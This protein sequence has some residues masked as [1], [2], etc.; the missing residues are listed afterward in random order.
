[1]PSDSWE[2]QA[3]NWLGWARTPCHDA[4]WDY[5]SG[6]FDHIVPA[7]GRATLDLGCGEGRVARD[8]S[9]R[10]HRVI[11]LD[12]S[13]T[14]LAAAKAADPGGAFLVAD[15]ARLPF[16]DRSFDQVVAHNSLM[17]IEDMAGAVHE[18]ARVLEPGGSL[19]ASVTHP[20]KDIGRFTDPSTFVIERPYLEAA[21]FHETF[22]RDGLTMTFTGWTHPIQDYADALEVAGLHI[23]RLREPQ[24]G[25]ADGPDRW[26]RALPM[27]LHIRAR[28]P[29]AA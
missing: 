28:K 16:A 23:T 13:P 7:P 24:P 18:V 21:R 22:A 9:L 26:R 8:L 6:F 5:R 15:A 4:Y 25:G 17:D 20:F 19:S 14:L 3:E 29:A 12:R 1:V 10:G 11:G 27:F 2:S